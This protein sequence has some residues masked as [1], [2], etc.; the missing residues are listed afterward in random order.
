M[1]LKAHALARSFGSVEAVTDASLEVRPGQV[2]GLIGPNG[3]GKT[4]TMLM[5]VGLLQPDS[6]WVEVD[7]KVAASADS[8]KSFSA[9]EAAAA[10]S[11]IGWMPDEFGSWD[12]LTTEQIL[13]IFAGLYDCKDPN[14]RVNEVIGQLDLESYR[15]KKIHTLSRGQKQRLGFARALIH[16]PRYLVLDEPANGMD[17]GARRDLQKFVRDYAATG[18]GVLV[19]SHILSELDDMVDDAVFM[20]AGATID[21]TRA[22]ELRW[23]VDVLNPEVWNQFASDARL[24][25]GSVP[26]SFVS[27]DEVAAG[28]II[29]AASAA[30]VRFRAIAPPKIDLEAQYMA[31][32][33]DGAGGA[34]WSA[35]PVQDGEAGGEER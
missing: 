4:T 5:M 33:R 24:N 10:R 20:R 15:S 18:A 28:E 7:G 19:S 31:M 27:T 32:E 1:S 16:R 9:D 21:A 6:G 13:S 11:L 26:F 17:P 30:G 23:H 22:L 34:H 25:T 29:A 14:K 12:A 3:C 8:S 35:A 2:L